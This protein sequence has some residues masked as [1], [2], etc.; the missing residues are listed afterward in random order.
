MNVNKTWACILSLAAAAALTLSYSAGAKAQDAGAKG[1]ARE[2]PD[3]RPGTDPKAAFEQALKAYRADTGDVKA[4]AELIRRAKEAKQEGAARKELQ[5]A[6]EQLPPRPEVVRAVAVGY[7]LL[8]DRDESMKAMRALAGMTPISSKGRL[9]VAAGMMTLGKAAEAEKL[10]GEELA[11]NPRSPNA[12]FVMGGLYARTRRRTQALE[13]Y[14]KAMGLDDSNVHYRL[15]LAQLLFEVGDLSEASLILAPVDKDEPRAA[16]LE[17]QIAIAEGRPVDAERILSKVNT[18]QYSALPLALLSLRTGQ[19]DRCI[20]ICRTELKK[21]DQPRARSLHSILAEALV[22]QGK[23]KE[24]AAHLTEALKLDPTKLMTYQRLAQVLSLDYKVTDIDRIMSNTPGADRNNVDLALGGLLTSQKKHSLARVVFERLADRASAPE[25][26]RFRARLLLADSLAREKRV[27]EALVHL[28][29]LLG[30]SEVWQKQGLLAKVTLLIAANRPKDAGAAIEEIRKWAEGKKDTALLRR[31]ARLYL[32]MKQPAKAAEICAQLRKTA[33][34]EAGTYLVQADVFLAQDKK[35]EAIASVNTAI[36]KRPRDFQ[37]YLVLSRLL[38]REEKRGEALAVLDRLAAAG[39]AG[40]SLAL[41]ER[42]RLLATWGLHAQA[43]EAFQDVA[44][45]GSG[46]NPSLLFSLGR[47]LAEMGR[48]SQARSRL[49]GVPAHA[50]T[51]VPAQIML[52]DLAETTEEGLAILARL[53]KAKPGVPAVL[54]KRMQFLLKDK[55]RAEAVKLF[56]A[57]ADA[58]PHKQSPPKVAPVA[59]GAMLEDGDHAGA[60]KLASAMHQQTKD[61]RWLRLAVLLRLDDQGGQAARMLPPLGQAGVHEATMALYLAARN[62]QTDLAKTWEGRLNSIDSQL[63]NM[64]PKRSLPVRLRLLAAL[65][66]GV[67]GM[68]N[69]YAA[70]MPSQALADGEVAKELVDHVAKAKTLGADRRKAAMTETLLLLKAEA[71]IMQGAPVLGRQWAMKAL[72]ARPS[73][74][75]AA[76]T[77]VRS[78][79]DNDTVRK[80]LAVL[81]PADCVLAKLVQAR[82]ASTDGQIDRALE[83]CDALAETLKDDPV[84]AMQRAVLTDRA[85]RTDEALRQYIEIASRT[86]NPVAANNAAYLTCLKFPKDQ[87]KL[88]KAEAWARAALR[89]APRL[90]ELRDTIGWVARLRGQDQVAVIELRRAVRAS[91]R[92][93]ESHYHLGVVEAAL[94]HWDQARW[95]LQATMDLANKAKAEGK[96]VLPSTAEVVKR[97]AEVL[98]KIKK[99]ASP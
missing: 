18:D 54:A 37:T 27:D 92:S 32:L 53:D 35:A 79:A 49:G 82:L 85:G 84:F 56:E 97:A 24:A 55:K 41:L 4:V 31:A 87:Q 19:I 61:P 52:A 71:A 62:G 65:T 95:H 36:E 2:T 76:T 93:V 11:K 7:G 72:Q 9:A 80:A 89:R 78:R 81:K 1:A 45:V 39:Q 58:Q 8:G 43:A 67:T 70:R 77:I 26:S 94:G 23:R 74:Q 75:W 25:D 50:K 90:V 10:L 44:K 34:D 14:R 51:Y 17:M 96:P 20:Q 59:L 15:S 40:K 13:M 63:W 3:T 42:G 16:L 98:A 83:I 46:K 57:F 48:K 12:Y 22:A 60:A 69:R 38:D 86:S 6:R 99:P 28:K 73:C 30:G 64:E 88:A 66:A 29:V 21:K 33:P 68:A 5:K 47:V 91:P